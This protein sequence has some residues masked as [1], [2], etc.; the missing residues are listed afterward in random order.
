MKRIK[1]IVK[2]KVQGVFFR[3]SIKE[4]ADILKIKGYA[5]NLPDGKSLEAV[6]EGEE[7]KIKQ[8]VK[9]CKKGPPLAKVEEVEVKEMPIDKPFE[10][11]KILY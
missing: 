7:N 3:A 5:R 8:M 6:F 4:L 10:D 1:V 11:F 9:F 2:G